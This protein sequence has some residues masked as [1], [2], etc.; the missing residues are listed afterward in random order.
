MTTLDVPPPDITRGAVADLRHTRQRRRLG[1][2]Q[3]GELAY[4]V[5]TTAFFCLVIVIMISGAIGDDPVSPSAV[6]DIAELG[7]KWAGLLLSLVILGGVRSGSRGGPLALEAADVQH[8]LLSPAD[9]TTT[10]RR[11]TLGLL[12]YGI[13]TGTAVMAVTG[14]F[15]SQRVPGGTAEFVWAGAL[16]G[17]VL[18]ATM[19]GSAL[20]T[21]SR[22]LPRWLLIGTA[23]ILLAWSVADIADRVPG[24]PTSLAGDLLFWPM[25]RGTPGLAWVAVAIVLVVVGTLTVGGLSIE[26]ARRRTQ[27]VGQ[28]RFAVTQQDLRSVVLLRRQLASEVPRNRRW[29]PVPALVARKWP[30]FGRDLHSV[31]HW[32]LIR[33]ARVTVLVCGAALAARAMFSGTTPLLVVAG[34]ATF[35]AATDATEG[36]SQEVDHPT[37][38]ESYPMA[39]GDVLLRHLVAPCVVMAL[40]GCLGLAVTYA[41]DPSTEVLRV[42]AIGLL[43][44]SLSAVAGAAISIVSQ[45]EV[46]TGSDVLMTPEVAGPRLVIR[47]VWPPLVAVAGFLPVLVAA[48]VGS[49]DPASAA[50]VTALPVLMLVAAVFGWVRFRDNIHASMAEA[51][52]G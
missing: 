30:I 27:L 44:A 37:L 9:R 11:P 42:G 36:L 23:W 1:D 13:F 15:I 4:R 22:L 45:I 39:Q 49:G 8:L 17:A 46:D 51:M 25:R 2:T 52:P 3:W 34:A 47:T 14:S 43:T 28:L 31:S 26:A 12:G 29:F 18:T 21:C 48:N 10:L 33:I 24:S 50:A 32:P 6:V 7:P 5:Y 41:F 16:F 38:L 19:F 20:L 40:A 35:I